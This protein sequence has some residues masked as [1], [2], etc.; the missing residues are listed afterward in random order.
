M[1]LLYF[2]LHIQHEQKYFHILNIRQPNRIIN[3]LLYYN[4]KY[5]KVFINIIYIRL[6]VQ[7]ILEEDLAK[8]LHYHYVNILLY[9]GGREDTF[10]FQ[11]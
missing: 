5:N 4:G 10:S 11:S 2:V 3:H 9:F 8:F 1:F 7:A 6:E